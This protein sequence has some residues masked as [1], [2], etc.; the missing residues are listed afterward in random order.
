MRHSNTK[1]GTGGISR[2]HGG[3]TVGYC[4]EHAYTRADAGLAM[5]RGEEDSAEDF[6]TRVYREL[7]ERRTGELALAQLWRQQQQLQGPDVHAAH[8]QPG[9]IDASRQYTHARE[10][11]QR[12]SQHAGG[13]DGHAMWHDVCARGEVPSGG[14]YAPGGPRRHL[15]EQRDGGK[16]T[17]G[18][19]RPLEEKGDGRRAPKRSARRSRSRSR[20]RS[21]D[22]DDSWRR[23]RVGTDEDP[24]QRQRRQQRRDE[25]WPGEPL[26]EHRDTRQPP[27]DRERQSWRDDVD[28]QRRSCGDRGNGGGGD[29][30]NDS[31]VQFYRTDA[32]A[33]GAVLLIVPNKF[34]PQ[35][36][37]HLVAEAQLM[38]RR[39][40]ETLGQASNA[41]PERRFCTAMTS[42][43]LRR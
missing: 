1:G 12:Q 37:P 33:P 6:Y 19:H 20:T 25:S 31:G 26:P 21:P 13:G 28:L 8:R 43:G 5:C 40:N 41:V 16:L 2:R 36:P 15:E 10:D 23:R 4:D 42:S 34:E 14:R 3:G 30:N 18:G 11:F 22:A 9:A 24:H 17:V 38:L 39:L 27:H 32:C 29:G 7:V 35:L